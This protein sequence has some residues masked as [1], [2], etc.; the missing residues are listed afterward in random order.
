MTSLLAIG[1]ANAVAAAPTVTTEPATPVGT[2]SATLRASLN[3]HELETTYYFEYG[4]T[5]AYG[6]KTAEVKVA[7][8]GSTSFPFAGISSLSQKTTYH[9]RFVAKN[10]DGTSSGADKTLTTLQDWTLQETPNIETSATTRLKDVSCLSGGECFAVGDTGNG[11]LT[12]PHAERWNGTAWSVQTTAGAE[13]GSLESISCTAT[14]AC[15]A[16]GYQTVGGF[17]AALAERW[18]G[19]SLK[20]QTVPATVG[21]TLT[22]VSCVSATEC[23]AVGYGLEGPAIAARWNGKEWLAIS[24]PGITASDIVCTSASFCMAT[25]QLSNDAT[26]STWNGSTWTKQTSLV[27]LQS[28]YR[29]VSCTA[30]NACTAVGY[31]DAPSLFVPLVARWDGSKWTV[32]EAP[33]PVGPEL[34]V[35]EGVAC[36][37]ATV[38]TATGF[39]ANGLGTSISALTERWNGTSW[40]M[41]QSANYPGESINSLGGVSCISLTVCESVGYH[42]LESGGASKT[43]ALAERSV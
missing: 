13:K 19:T 10:K 27:S 42:K 11:E 32:Q 6:S 16:V 30:S 29:A 21:N 12:A 37:S 1:A 15:T 8:S 28:D 2:E 34:M 5:A 18:D 31:K 17:K 41:Q 40:K 20:K 38:C 14:N 22:G 33:Y 35:L 39:S 4:L 24:G 3:T 23:I 36:T 26:S 7:G 43:R 25:G 9:F